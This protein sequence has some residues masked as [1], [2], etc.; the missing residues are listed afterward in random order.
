MVG[1]YTEAHVD[2]GIAKRHK[3]FIGRLAKSSEVRN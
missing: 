2:A 3:I 1:A